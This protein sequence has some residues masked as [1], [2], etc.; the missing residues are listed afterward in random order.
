MVSGQDSTRAIAR[1]RRD[2]AGSAADRGRERSGVPGAGHTGLVGIEEALALGPEAWDELARRAGSVSP[3]MSWAWHRAWLDTAPPA[4]T[5][6]AVVVVQVRSDG[7]LDA[8]LPLVRRTIHVRRVPVRAWGWLLDDRGCPDHLDLL[9]AP[10]A[11][12]SQLAAT[13]DSL[14]WRM[15]HLS[16]VAAD[17]PRLSALLELLN[18]G[19]VL[20]QERPRWKAPCIELPADWDAYLASHGSR[21]RHNLRRNERLLFDDPGVTLTA[22]TGDRVDEGLDHLFSLHAKRWAHE[23]HGGA[24]A[25]PAVEALHRQFARQLGR[26]GVLRLMTLDIDGRPAAAFYGFAHGDTVYFYQTGRDP[27]HEKRRVGSVII[28]IAVRRAIEEG[29]RRFDFL[30]GDEPYKALWARHCRTTREVTVYRSGLHGL[31]P[32]AIERAARVLDARHASTAAALP[33]GAGTEE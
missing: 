22:Y 8:I 28:G 31:I 10:D 3:F 20:V 25:E 17:S 23:A 24:F 4:A 1:S 2:E 13:V 33:E 26:D 19:R 16:N 15:L 11:D 21:S 5:R 14:P 32:R 18:G 29:F 27:E 9:A 6:A 7:R 12:L 30:R